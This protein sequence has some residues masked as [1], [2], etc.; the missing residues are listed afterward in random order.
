MTHSVPR[1]FSPSSLRI[2]RS[3]PCVEGC[4]GPMLR[5]SSVESKNVA[6]GIPCSLA[7]FDLQVLP[8]PSLVLL[9]YRIVLSERVSLPFFRQEDAPHIGMPGE[10]DA[11]HVEDLPLQPIAAQVHGDGSLGLVALGDVRLD[12]EALVARETVED[13]DDV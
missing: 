8:H 9:N 10:L 1:I 2:T 6:S 12:A 11:E 5:T 4:C 3:T 7:A 13:V